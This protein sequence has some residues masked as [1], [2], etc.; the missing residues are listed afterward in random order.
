MNRKVM[1]ILLVS[2][3]VLLGA[4]AFTAVRLLNPPESNDLPAGAQVFEDVYDDGSGSPVTVKT[5]IL[6]A[7]ELPTEEFAAGGVF[8][9][10]EDNSYFVGTG[11]TS[12]NVQ[13]ENG[14]PQVAV[15]HSGPEVEVVVTQGTI[16][17]EDITEVSFEASESKEQTLQQAVRQVDP[18][19]DL[20]GGASI[21]AWGERRGDRVVAT[22]IVFAETR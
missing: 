21:T 7:T 6:P 12:V 14:E 5:V 8:L 10:Q 17:Y 20:Q 16:F 13:I 18:P 22:L 9:R 11:S 15:D 19:T 4:G 2:V 3:L 1:A